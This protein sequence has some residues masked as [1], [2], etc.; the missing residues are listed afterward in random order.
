MRLVE[1]SV[2]FASCHFH[3]EEVGVIV[4][5]ILGKRQLFLGEDRVEN[6]GGLERLWG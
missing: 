2:M 5:E 4:D 6:K 1:G 3:K